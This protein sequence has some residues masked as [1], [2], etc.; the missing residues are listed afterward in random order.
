MVSVGLYVPLKAKPG[1]EA[2]V[3]AFLESGR[4]SSTTNPTPKP[5]SIKLSESELAIVDFFP[6]DSG[7][8][9]H[10]SGK[11][12]E[13]LMAKADELFASRPTSIRSTWWPRSFGAEV[14]T[15]EDLILVT[16]SRRG[17]LVPS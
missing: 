2:E 14:G 5:G 13:A 1:K 4:H 10:L 3:E 11:V 16:S 17:T 6:D 8:R 15:R 12:A 7:R 9:A